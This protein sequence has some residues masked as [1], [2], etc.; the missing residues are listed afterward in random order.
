MINKNKQMIII[1]YIKING[2]NVWT[3][4]MNQLLSQRIRKRYYKTLGTSV[5][6]SP[7]S[8]LSHWAWILVFLIK[9]WMYVCVLFLNRFHLADIWRL[10]LQTYIVHPVKVLTFKI[11]FKRRIPL[12]SPYNPSRKN[13]H[14]KSKN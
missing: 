11:N 13:S 1:V 10:S 4:L 14:R 3:N 2:W 8:Q 7:L 12:V 6:N 5:L 9:C